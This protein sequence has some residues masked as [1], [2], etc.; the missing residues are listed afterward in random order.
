MK[1]FVVIIALLFSVLAFGE[2]KTVYEKIFDGK[3]DIKTVEGLFKLHKIDQSII[4]EIPLTLFGKAMKI[5][6]IVEQTSN[7]TAAPMGLSVG[8]DFRLYFTRTDSLVNIRQMID[9]APITIEEDLAASFKSSYEDPIYFSFPIKTFSPDSTA[10][11]C[12]LTSL[13]NNDDRRFVFMKAA[14]DNALASVSNKYDSGLSSLDDVVAYPDHLELLS[15]KTYESFSSVMGLSSSMGKTTV[16]VRTILSLLPEEPMPIR[17]ADKRVGTFIIEKSS[18]SSKGSKDVSYATR[19]RLGEEP[20]TFYVDTLFSPTWQHAIIDGIQAWNKAFKAIGYESDVLKAEL[21]PA[22]D[23]TFNLYSFNCVKLSQTSLRGVSSKLSCDSRSGEILSASITVGRDFEYNVLHPEAVFFMGAFNEALRSNRLPDSELY[24]LV[25]AVIMRETGACLGLTYNYLASS[26]YTIEQLRDPAFTAAHGFASSVMTPLNFNYLIQK[27]D[28]EKGAVAVM[29]DLGPYDYYAIKWL[30]A[31]DSTPIINTP[32]YRYSAKSNIDPR[33]TQYSIGDDII[34]ATKLAYNNLKIS[35]SQLD[36]WIIDSEVYEGNM[37]LMTDFLWLAARDVTM[38]L[39]TALG[40]YYL[41]DESRVSYS[42]VPI[43]KQ[44]EYMKFGLECF[45]DYSWLNNENF[46]KPY[47]LVHNVSNRME[48]QQMS[49]LLSFYLFKPKTMIDNSH[50]ELLSYA[51]SLICDRI[52]TSKSLLYGDLMAVSYLYQSLRSCVVVKSQQSEGA[53][54]RSFALQAYDPNQGIK[55]F[56]A[57]VS[58]GFYY[59]LLIKLQK[60]TAKAAKINADKE[61]QDA[62]LKFSYDISRIINGQ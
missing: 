7:M 46:Y 55:Y 43:E 50:E 27:E 8:S 12:D 37:T 24:K 45:R 53:N 32:E 13:F 18:F 39:K 47:C 6:S 41:G 15:T 4:A 59:D 54:G 20:I 31:Q 60:A 29:S 52:T 9:G 2:E 3:K 51:C 44:K 56:S 14:S 17:I 36:K 30:Y 1:K 62:M 19:F 21:Y 34:T 10:I 58:S 11:V 26:A 57:S 49:E 40:G 38:P 28:F 35:A 48:L 33:C 42:A 25:K 23:T 5:N 61:Q 22:N 16:I